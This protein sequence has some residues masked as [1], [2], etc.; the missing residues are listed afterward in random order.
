MACVI[1]SRRDSNSR[2]GTTRCAD[3]RWCVVTRRSVA[4]VTSVRNSVPEAAEVRQHH[5]TSDL[6]CANFMRYWQFTIPGWVAGGSA[7]AAPVYRA[8]RIGTDCACCDV[9]DHPVGVAVTMLTVT[10]DD[11]LKLSATR[12]LE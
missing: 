7:G 6:G 9:A 3:D 12:L 5:R 10:P 2:Q 4:R 8:Q 1:P 11:G